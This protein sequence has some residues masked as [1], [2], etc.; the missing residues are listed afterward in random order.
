MIATDP[1]FFARRNQLAALASRYAIPTIHF[2]RAFAAAGGLISYGAT[3]TEETRMA[4]RYTG[5]IL[6]GE[7]PGALP[8]LQPSSI[9]PVINLKSAKTPGLP[10]PPTT[11]G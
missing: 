4:G 6:A 10:E 11:L 7:N 9:E 2:H 8:I 3:I 1:F 5:R